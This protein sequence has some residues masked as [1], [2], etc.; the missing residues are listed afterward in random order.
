[1]K[2]KK[3]LANTTVATMLLGSFTT[4]ASAEENVGDIPNQTNTSSQ[5]NFIPLPPK[6][7]DDIGDKGTFTVEGVDYNYEFKEDLN[8]GIREFAFGE[9]EERKV[10][11]YDMNKGEVT[12][13]GQLVANNVVTK[14]RITALPQLN[15]FT[16]GSDKGGGVYDFKY[17]D[18]GSF[19]VI[20]ATAV[21][22]GAILI[23]TVFKKNPGKTAG[24]TIAAGILSAVSS[25]NFTLR[26]NLYHYKSS[27]K[28]WYQDSINFY[29]GLTGNNRVYNVTH[30]YGVL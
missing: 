27:K 22:L 24:V 26:W 30:Y 19:N 13:D 3:I 12:L 15:D 29:K 7:N 28:T 8:K 1:M 6:N 9:G 17:Y 16:I 18:E 2:I 5:K 25:N 21:T 10:A 11:I 20:S 23:A 14:E 4:V